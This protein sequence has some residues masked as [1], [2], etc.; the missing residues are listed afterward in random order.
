MGRQ[1]TNCVILAVLCAAGGLFA[2]PIHAAIQ[3]ASWIGGN[4]DWLGSPEL[5]SPANLPNNTGSSQYNVVVSAPSPNPYYGGR[6][7]VTFG[8]AAESAATVTINNLVINNKM[9][10]VA[11]Y[12]G[13]MDLGGAGSPGKLAID[14]GYYYISGGLLE[15][16]AVA[17]GS[18][19]LFV[20]NG[21]T[22]KNVTVDGRNAVADFGGLNIAN[23]AAAPDPVSNE[24]IYFGGSNT[25]LS[26]SD[27]AGTGGAAIGQTLINSTIYDNGFESTLDAGQKLTIGAGST[28]SVNAFGSYSA[29]ATPLP[30]TMTGGSI[31]NDGAIN[32]TFHNAPESLGMNQ[33]GDITINPSNF[34]NRGVITVLP[35]CNLTISAAN[36]TN[37]G[38]IQAL[39]SPTPGYGKYYSELTFGGDWSNSG[40]IALNHDTGLSLGGNFKSSDIGLAPG[41][42]VL[43][44]N[45]AG[46]AIT[47]TMDNTG[48]SIAFNSTTGGYGL[49]GTIVGGTISTIDPK[50]G[51][52]YLGE[53]GPNGGTLRS[54]TLGT[55]LEAQSLTVQNTPGNDAGLMPNGHTLIVDGFI[56]FQNTAGPEVFNNGAI[57]APYGGQISGT[58]WTIGPNA[59][60]DMARPLSNQPDNF[61][62]LGKTSLTNYAPVTVGHMKLSLDNLQIAAGNFTNHGPITSDGTLDINAFSW[63]NTSAI[64]INSYGVLYTSGNW[65][66]TG[67]ITAAPNSQIFLGGTFHASDVGL[68][69]GGGTF[70]H[71]SM[72]QLEITGTM[73]LGGQTV[74]FG[75]S[76]G[77]WMLNGG[78]IANGSLEIAKQ[79]YPN[80]WLTVTGNTPSTLENVKV[81][82]N[83][84]L[85]GTYSTLNI[86]NTGS[87]S[88]V[89]DLNGQ[90]ITINGSSVALA[91]GTKD[92]GLQYDGATISNGNITIDGGNQITTPTAL[93]ID[94]GAQITADTGQ[95]SSA[96]IQAASINL[97]GS[98]R[99]ISNSTLY[100]DPSGMTVGGTLEADP[101]SIIAVE[102]NLALAS[103]GNFTVGLNS[104]QIAGLE[105]GGNL[106]LASGS[107]L[108][109]LPGTGLLGGH[110]YKLISYS[111]ALSGTF[112][113]V[114]PGYQLNYS[115]A[116]EILATP[117]PEAPTLAL[118][119]LAIP[120]LSFAGRKRRHL[121]VME[122][123]R[124][125]RRRPE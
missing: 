24:V 58:T 35:L 38:T 90:T 115:A 64:T 21:G 121:A 106:T 75:P 89:L 120:L 78:T 11:Q 55:N 37:S 4:G 95:N 17:T 70:T 20:V 39:P 122:P 40:V 6:Y 57:S 84:S 19:G 117:V 63:T 23:T 50:T 102:T 116:G 67:S 34:D 112:S 29:N 72:M 82:G 98:I 8:G 1:R 74:T 111:G 18:D 65:S 36:W 61:T 113:S 107:V 81:I 80:L 119:C 2:H 123:G 85:G 14:A 10:A 46:V 49:E 104:D 31:T 103:R 99:A 62:L 91:L 73:D 125:I 12:G 27:A 108:N 26:F 48:D 56:N 79:T 76:T 53:G 94:P 71:P 100:I 42:G 47:G 25:L 66:N 92:F 22:L 77:N 97:L 7:G 88:D 45:G 13:T 5:W 114:T 86:V 33:M 15:N 101:S 52:N 69:P 124:R 44:P 105:I 93:T 3:T 68:A 110:W 32:V 51:M 118:L 16:A 83:W 9:A 54:V 30:A 59:S 87:T 28:L 60:V 109:I 41:G 96:T 43:A